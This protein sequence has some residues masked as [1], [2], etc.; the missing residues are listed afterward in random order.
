MQICIS[1]V[2][3]LEICLKGSTSRILVGRNPIPPSFLC[4][5]KKKKKA[6]SL[7]M[8][9][10]CPCKQGEETIWEFPL[11]M[12]TTVTYVQGQPHL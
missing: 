1:H 5:K 11:S 9:N 12:T 4:L 8:L 3:I 10:I 2:P 7:P 6:Y